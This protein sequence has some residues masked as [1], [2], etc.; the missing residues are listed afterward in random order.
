MPR[1]GILINDEKTTYLLLSRP[2]H[3]RCGT[4]LCIRHVELPAVWLLL[5]NTTSSVGQ[6]HYLSRQFALLAMFSYY[7]FIAQ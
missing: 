7:D 2:V 1:H 4:S 5:C 3:W 6:Q